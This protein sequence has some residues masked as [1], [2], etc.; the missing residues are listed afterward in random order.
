MSS[1]PT[2]RDTERI[3]W[4]ENEANAQQKY[5]NSNASSEGCNGELSSGTLL[6]HQNRQMFYKCAAHMC[7]TRKKN[8]TVHSTHTEKAST[9]E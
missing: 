1:E 3:E 4:E 9:A 2:E 6:L 8:T 5:N 7:A